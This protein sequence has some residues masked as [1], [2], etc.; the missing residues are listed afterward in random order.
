NPVDGV[1]H[2]LVSEI[3][4]AD[5]ICS[6]EIMILW[7]HDHR[8]FVVQRDDVQ[9][10][11]ASRHGKANKCR[12]D[13]ATHDRL[14]PALRAEGH[15][16]QRNIWHA[17]APPPRPFRRS[18]SFGRTKTKEAHGRWGDHGPIVARTAPPAPYS[19]ADALAASHLGWKPERFDRLLEETC[20]LTPR[21]IR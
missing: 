7:H 18:D 1:K 16:L 6:A 10:L 17:P 9:L 20:L 2:H 4:R 14:F 8:H 15:E 21:R 5:L 11:L 19:G 12:V 13:G 3:F